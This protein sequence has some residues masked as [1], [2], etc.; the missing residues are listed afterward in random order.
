MIEELKALRAKATKGPFSVHCSNIY[1]PDGALIFTV[2][3]P[4]AKEADYPLV[5]NRDLTAALLNNLDRI[6]AQA[7][8]LEFIADLPDPGEEQER[9]ATFYRIHAAQLKQVAAK[10]LGRQ[11]VSQEALDWAA[12]S[13]ISGEVEM[14]QA[15]ELVEVTREDE[16]RG[17]DL[18]KIVVG[19]VTAGP[20]RESQLIEA[21]MVACAQHRIAATAALATPLSS[22]AIAESTYRYAHDTFGGGDSRTGRA[23][24]SLRRA[25]DKARQAL[26]TQ[27]GEHKEESDGR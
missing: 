27:P 15:T 21:S 19:L 17:R 7:E 4:G 25:G 14:T 24:D 12:A 13:A 3:N 5:T 2:H 22:L 1:A 8:A 11:I 9:S 16:D 18:A 20:W 26:A 23:W 10:A 6:I